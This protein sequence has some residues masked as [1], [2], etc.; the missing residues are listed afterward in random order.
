MAVARA[1]DN[2][3]QWRPRSTSPSTCG[4]FRGCARTGLITHAAGNRRY[5]SKCRSGGADGAR[6]DGRAQSSAR[7]RR[8]ISKEREIMTKDIW[9]CDGGIR[10]T[11][12]RRLPRAFP[13]RAR[14][15]ALLIAGLTMPICGRGRDHDR[16]KARCG[17][18]SFRAMMG[19]CRGARDSARAGAIARLR[20]A[21][22]PLAGHR[23]RPYIICRHTSPRHTACS[24]RSP[25][26]A[27]GQ[28]LQRYSAW[29]LVLAGLANTLI[30][31]LAPI[32]QAALWSM[33][34][35]A[36]G[37][38]LIALRIASSRSTRGRRA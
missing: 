38:A 4:A 3:G 36:A 2:A 1:A 24:I 28:R 20:S 10:W 22:A 15:R 13:A 17:W 25:D 19:P 21:R 27:R 31:A 6:P 37:L 16:V 9:P 29:V 18:A 12:V 32:K 11:L 33:V 34:P 23:R 8:P 35:L 14:K 7:R 26:A 5:D 30:W